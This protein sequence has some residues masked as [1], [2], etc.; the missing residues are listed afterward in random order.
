LAFGLSGLLAGLAALLYQSGLVFALIVPLWWVGV[1]LL[2]PAWFWRTRATLRSPG[3]VWLGG[4]FVT[5][6]PLLA[7]WLRAP[8]LLAARVQPAI[9]QNLGQVVSVFNPAADQI[10]RSGYPGGSLAVLVAPLW[11]LAIGALLL[12]L[13]RLVGWMLFTW[14]AVGLLVGSALA[15]QTPD[16]PVLLPLLPALALT[17]AL[18]L[19][20]IRVTLVETA[21]V[22]L[23]QATTYLAIS[24]VLWSGLA[25]WTDYVQWAQANGDAASYTGRA[26]RTLPPG[27]TPVLLLGQNGEQIDSNSPVVHFFRG[28]Q[29]PDRPQVAFSVDDWPPSLPPTST[30]LIQPQD[31]GVLGEIEMRFPG[32]TLTVERDLHANP[33]LY[34]YALP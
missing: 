32:G 28:E 2:Q 34:L 25:T 24:L 21:G 31:A 15:T 7:V 29:T 23:V 8:G 33:I 4:F 3:L 9:F 5:L 27:R 10:T 16:W 20:R 11:I 1:W 18:T 12:N 14:C 30:L 13:D 19:D 6:S 26:L 22:W 17:I